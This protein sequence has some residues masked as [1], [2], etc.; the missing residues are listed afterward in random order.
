MKGKPCK[1]REPHF[2]DGFVEKPLFFS[3]AFSTAV[4]PKRQGS[5]P[6]FNIFVRH[7]YDY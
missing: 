6:V 1:N 2:F 4:F 3:T 7:Y 5:I